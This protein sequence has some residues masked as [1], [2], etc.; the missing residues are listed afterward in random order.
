MQRRELLSVLGAAAAWPLAARARESDRVRR[1]GLLIGWTE[2]DPD[3]RGFVAAFVEELARLGWIDGRN[4]RIEQR[5]TNADVNR[6]SAFAK[7]LVAS[8][9]DVI[10]AATTPATAALHR[11]TSTIPI[12]FTIVSDPVGAGFVTGLPRP[13]GNITGFTHTD[14][15]LGGK[16][17]GLL[18]EIAPGIK[19]AGIMFNPDTAPGSGNLFLGSFE[20][21]A[22]SLAVEPVTM[23]VRSDA[24]IEAAI[25]ALGRE[26]AGLAAMDDSFMGVHY[27]TVISS[28]AR[29]NVPAIFVAQAF[30]RDGGLISYGADFTDLELRAARYVDRI[31]RGEKP[32]DLPVQFPTKF[33]MVVNLKTAKALGLTVPQSILLRADEVIE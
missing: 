18:K 3:L 20:A 1:V 31:L 22:R 16:W 25:A 7:E 12:V 14:A 33:E 8:Q 21:A 23:R 15:A 13:G 24:E 4:A 28:S 10:L 9:P 30:V 19:R 32:G 17:L 27:R 6:T 2:S 26:Q 29:N 11:E 5:W